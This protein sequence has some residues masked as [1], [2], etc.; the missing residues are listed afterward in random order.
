LVVLALAF[1][2]LQAGRAATTTTTFTA[3]I[4]IQDNCQII[5]ADDLDFGSVVSLTANV[6]ATAIVEV[7]CTNTTPYNVGLNEGS[8]GGTIAVRLMTSGSATV[9]YTMYSNA[10]RTTLWGN[11]IGTNTVSGIGNGAA[12]QLTIYGR[13]PIQATPDPDTYADTVTITVTY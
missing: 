5:S 9:D 12:Q 11:T 13:V 2:D 1:G 4:V 7:Q 8:S 3:Q 10:A 6:D